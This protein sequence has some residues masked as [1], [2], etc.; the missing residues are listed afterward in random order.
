ML[1]TLHSISVLQ[2][3]SEIVLDQSHYTIFDSRNFTSSY[4]LE[5]TFHRISEKFINIWENGIK[6]FIDSMINSTSTY[7]VANRRSSLA[8]LSEEAI[9]LKLQGFDY[10]N[11]SDFFISSDLSSNSIRLIA[12][13][14]DDNSEIN[15]SLSVL[16]SP[17][18]DPVHG[19]Y[20]KY[21]TIIFYKKL[22]RNYKDDISALNRILLRTA[23]LLAVSYIDLKL[24]SDN[25]VV[26]NRVL[27]NNMDA[28]KDAII[29]PE[30]LNISDT[31]FIFAYYYSLF[32]ILNSILNVGFLNFNYYTE[33]VSLPFI[34]SINMTEE[35]IDEFNAKLPSMTSDHD[36][37]LYINMFRYKVYNK[38]WNFASKGSKIRE[39]ISA[40]SND[41]YID[42][43][44]EI[45][46]ETQINLD[47]A[48]YQ[49]QEDLNDIYTEEED[50]EDSTEDDN[51]EE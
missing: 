16:V 25:N 1:H 40:I 49:A 9:Y 20:Q 7:S 23:N 21:L 10:T 19:E 43:C 44:A 8:L 50:N 48:Y 39:G 27:A 5:D 45:M 35:E 51:N 37:E 22:F 14:A 11:I 2:A 34:F 29:M 26:L 18:F 46:R 33:A 12:I 41:D 4:N 47:D 15:N 42:I 28:N 13:D 24:S 32:Y 36:K 30:A 38:I 17:R 3:N 6:P 31:R